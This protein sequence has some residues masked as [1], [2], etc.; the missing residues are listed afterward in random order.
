M[1][2]TWPPL[3]SSICHQLI[4]AELGMYLLLLLGLSRA[5]G[6][7]PDRVCDRWALNEHTHMLVV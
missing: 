3:G 2:F 6:N 5:V 7:N 4:A 1:G